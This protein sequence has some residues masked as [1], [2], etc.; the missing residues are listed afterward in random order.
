MLVVLLGFCF[1]LKM[2]IFITLRRTNNLLC[3]K[4]KQ[5]CTVKKEYIDGEGEGYCTTFKYHC[6][7]CKLRPELAD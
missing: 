5:K 3:P 6:K 1:S 2:Q 4:C 7:N